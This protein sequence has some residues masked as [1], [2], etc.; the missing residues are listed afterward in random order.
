MPFVRAHRFERCDV[1][2]PN[3]DLALVTLKN[4][5]GKRFALQLRKDDVAELLGEFLKI[6]S[7]LTET[8]ARPA[9]ITPPHRITIPVTEFSVA[10]G[11]K[12]GEVA[13]EIGIGGARLTTLV[14]ARLAT[15]M[16]ATLVNEVYP[17][18]IVRYTPASGSL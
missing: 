13:V 7:L 18:Q 2:I 15:S 1:E 16:C 12:E 5:K 4:T 10:P 11:R 3:V 17:N 14:P 9:D 8:G 6:A